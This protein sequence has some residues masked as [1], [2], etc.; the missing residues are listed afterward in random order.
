[1]RLSE[2]DTIVVDESEMERLDVEKVGDTAK[3]ND[4]TVKIVGQ[5]SGMKSIAGPYVFCSLSTARNI[6]RYRPDQASYLLARCEHP[7]DA[8]I[9]AQ[10]LKE[11]YGEDISA[12]TKQEFSRRSRMHW[13]VKTKAGIALGYAAALGLLVGAVVTGQTLYAATMASMRE[14]AT[15]LALGIPRWRLSVNVI[16]QAFWIGI[17]GVAVSVPVTYGL[18]ELA[19]IFGVKPALPIELLAAAGAITLVVSLAAGVFAL[20]SIR[21]IEPVNLLR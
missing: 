5:V 17:L 19:G 11:V 10:R 6:L 14:Y 8:P 16:T 12:F 2:P 9:V 18:G 15:L 13:L 3:I 21:Q 7:E 1:M 4:R 20:R